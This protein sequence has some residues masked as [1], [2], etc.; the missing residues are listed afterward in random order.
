MDDRIAWAV[1]AL[2]CSLFT[3]AFL[4]SLIDPSRRVDPGL[5]G[6]MGTVL[7]FCFSSIVLNRSKKDGDDK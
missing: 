6:L 4:V 5:Y 2:V 1:I 3:V 7:T